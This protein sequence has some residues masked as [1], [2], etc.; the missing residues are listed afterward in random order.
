MRRVGIG[1]RIDRDH[2]QAE[3]SRGARDADGDFAAIGDQDRGEHVQAIT[4]GR[5]ERHRVVLERYCLAVGLS[6]IGGVA[7]FC[8]A[9]G[10]AGGGGRLVAEV[11]AELVGGTDAAS[12]AAPCA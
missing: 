7:L 8:A 3:A 5:R 2:A 6:D 11:G 10:A 4:Q 12:C 1:F 9:F